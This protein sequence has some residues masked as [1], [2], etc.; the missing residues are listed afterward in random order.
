MISL[1]FETTV[2]HG[3]NNHITYSLV[4]IIGTDLFTFFK[5]VNNVQ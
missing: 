2:D 4:M 5:L 3:T 1:C